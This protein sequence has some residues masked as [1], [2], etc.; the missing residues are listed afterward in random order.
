MQQSLSGKHLYCFFL[1]YMNGYSGYSVK[2]TA[3]HLFS[4]IVVFNFFC[5]WEGGEEE[6]SEG[7]SEGRGEFGIGCEFY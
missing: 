2:G 5:Y 6:R 4:S 7:M 1:V 3:A